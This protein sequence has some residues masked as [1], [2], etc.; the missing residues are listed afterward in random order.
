MSRDSDK[1]VM[2]QGH[3]FRCIWENFHFTQECMAGIL[4]DIAEGRISI[5]KDL[6]N[7]IIHQ[8]HKGFQDFS[9]KADE[10]FD[11]FIA[12]KLNG[13]SPEDLAD[14]LYHLK[15]W[16]EKHNLTF[17]G[18]NSNDCEEWLRRMLSC[19][20]KNFNTCE[21]PEKR[22]T[23]RN[24]SVQLRDQNITAASPFLGRQEIFAEIS[25]ALNA[26]YAAVLRGMA[27][28]GKS[29]VARQFAALHREKYPHIQEVSA[30]TE[31]PE[32][33]M[34]RV[35]LKVK[36]DG[37]RTGRKPEE[38][39]FAAK[40]EAL[41]NLKEDS[42][43]IIDGLDTFPED[44]NILRDIL[45]DSKLRIIITTRLTGFF[46]NM[47]SLN[48]PA[49]E[50]S[51]QLELFEAHYGRKA[52]TPENMKT[53]RKILAYGDGNTM[54]IEQLARYI[55]ICEYTFDEALACLHEGCSFPEPWFVMKDNTR[56]EDDT[57]LGV[58][59]KILFPREVSAE[60]V[61]VLQ[62]L[63]QIPP[64]GMPRRKVL[65]GFDVQTRKELRMLED[66]GYALL[67]QTQE[68]NIT[69]IHPLIRS[70][71]RAMFC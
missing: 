12:D 6:M 43:L 51:E 49:L 22:K 20:L 44:I 34:R 30:D 42:L 50:L 21:N 13:K 9:G 32:D 38:D 31:H 52:S 4:E 15:K 17:R 55:K 56:Y 47:K 1:I 8:K 54:Y 58:F 60:R 23:S 65:E 24:S 39:V 28:I 3:V 59:S 68:Q 69:K 7:R 63:A 66:E 16:A 37:M 2:N 61:R 27:G 57:L 70:V 10:I 45:R 48:V 62:K 29:F 14:T 5:K 11:E 46:S 33:I 40:L 26:G 25:G 36:F 18:I 53:L 67:E 64:E 35:I 71:I 41:R 19:S